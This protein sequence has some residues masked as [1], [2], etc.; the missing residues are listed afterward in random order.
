MSIDPELLAAYADGEL[1]P[2][3]AARVEAAIA[4]NPALAREVD[5][6][7][8]LREQLREHFAPIAALPVPDR[9][10]APLEQQQASD[11]EDNIV[12][13]AQV[14]RTR[15][16]EEAARAR[17]RLGKSRW[18]LGGAIAAALV[19]GLFM[20]GDYPRGASFTAR[21][22]Q[23]IASGPLEDALTN[24]LAS[25]SDERPVRILL[26][27][28]SGEGR[29]CRGFETG[30]T[31]GIACRE[32]GDWT[33]VRTQASEGAEQGAY[34]QAGSARAEIMAAAQD[35]AAGEALAPQAERAAREAGWRD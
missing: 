26:S 13:L 6:H 14:R 34:R 29:Y 5:A 28:R 4:A 24:Q 33:V 21:D 7:R 32:G 16:E 3:E 1:G 35:M 15:Q 27:F 30:A 8:A 31:A 10:R 22:G 19:L 23:I 20:A 2:E 12:D 11:K 25:A 17:P 18:V 9:L